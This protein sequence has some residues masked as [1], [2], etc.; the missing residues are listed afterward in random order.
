M[1]QGSEARTLC[2]DVGG[3]GI[4][5]TI[6]DSSGAALSERVRVETPRPA[7]PEAVTEMVGEVAR[8]SGDFDR[9]SVGFPGVVDMV[10]LASS[11]PRRTSTAT[12]AASRSAPTSSDV[13]GRR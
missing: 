7:T 10:E 11:T 6:Y 13:S 4:K 1:S 9:V 5:A 3:T 2:V 12:G 8:R